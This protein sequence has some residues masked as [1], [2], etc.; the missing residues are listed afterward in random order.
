MM[1]LAS[2]LGAWALTF[3]ARRSNARDARG[4]FHGALAGGVV[5][6]LA[7]SLALVAGPLTFQMDPTRHVYEATV[8]VLVAWTVLHVLVGVVMQLYCMA[9]RW[10]GREPSRSE[11][12]WSIGVTAW[13][14]AVK[15]GSP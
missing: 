10:A 3:L 7:G 11:A 15:S 2:L 12:I 6:A 8:W 13:K 1:A 9:R 4:A 14:K 5:L